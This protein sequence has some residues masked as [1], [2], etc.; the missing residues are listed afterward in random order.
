MANLAR[1]KFVT[2]KT[3]PPAS[4][5]DGRMRLNSWC[6]VEKRWRATA[7]QNAG[8]L[9]G[10]ERTARSVLECAS[11]LALWAEVR[12][13]ERDCGQ[14]G[15]AQDGGDA[16]GSP[17]TAGF[18][19]T[20]SVD[21]RKFG[22]MK[23][24]GPITV[25]RSKKKKSTAWFIG[26]MIFCVLQ[27]KAQTI[28]SFGTAL[29]F[30]ADGANPSV[31]L[32]LSGSTLYGA[33]GSGGSTGS[34]VIFKMNTDGT[35]YTVL[36]TLNGH[37]GAGP[38]GDIP[39]GLTLSGSILY[40]TTSY[41]GS[42]GLGTVFKINTDGTGYTN[43]YSFTGTNGDGKNP[44]SGQN[45]VL[46]GNTLYGTTGTGG[47][48]GYGMIFKINLDGT[49]YTRLYSFPS[50]LYAESGLVLSGSILYGWVS[51]LNSYTTLY[52]INTD[53]TGYVKLFSFNTDT[54]SDNSI[55]NFIISGSF[56][57]GT[58]SGSSSVAGKVFKINTDGT[59][60]TVLKS[61]AGIIPNGGNPT[62]LVL[63][64]SILYGATADGGFNF[65][66][67]TDGIGT[68]FKINT[69][70]TG[71]TT[72]Y[73][74]TGINSDGN[75]PLGYLVLS[76]NNL[77]GTTYWGGSV[78]YGTVFSINLSKS[79]AAVT[80]GNLNQTYDGTAKSPIAATTPSG[81]TVVFAY[82]GSLDYSPINV[83]SYNVVGTISDLNYQGSATNIL[84]IGKATAI[85]TINSLSI[86]YDGTAK[87]AT[88]T[89]SPNGL[90]V[91]F[92]YDGSSAPPINT[93][94]YTVIGTVNDA[95][96]Q[97]KATNTLT[98]GLSP[99]I[100]F[101]PTNQTVIATSNATFFVTASGSSP[102]AYNWMFNNNEIIGATNVSLT[103]SNAQITYMGNYQA[104]VTNTYGITTSMVAS[105]TVVLPNYNQI[106]ANRLS[107]GKLSL[108]FVGIAA[109]NYA[110]DRS[111]SLSPIN[112]IPQVTNPADAN[113]NLAFTNTPDS[114][115]NN[116]WRI[117]SVP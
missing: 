22:A 102:L 8:A 90:A 11:P 3:P 50:G 81:K 84:V 2:I 6:A 43:L 38:D 116:F 69:D 23:R 61:F 36:K 113:G 37:F 101:Q 104:I 76:G 52:K 25:L 53:G 48:S 92:T 28:H 68:V 74:F 62:G 4:I 96:Y 10:D 83:G 112:W 95:N 86:A 41:G 64:G 17:E 91:T 27:L 78:D 20:A 80:L 55:D 59:G 9:T 33:T 54:S 71:Y 31:G 21:R 44:L 35:A 115:T 85:V 18:F 93:G 30:V 39:G 60:Y 63:S 5:W 51:A 109:E 79:I 65:S 58:T 7:L 73:S 49:G 26:L 107:N 70:G 13:P 98:I 46:Y 1:R 47:S 114:T 110:L 66:S 94:S 97:G 100:T 111:F 45:L 34:G 12:L 75:R 19:S 72:I 99:Q 106:F 82:N 14:W 40:G 24:S 29:G 56:L 117:R 15:T 42:Y 57:Y 87:R 103:I 88:A 89:T 108:S 67:D 16:N 105:L 32:L 77:Y